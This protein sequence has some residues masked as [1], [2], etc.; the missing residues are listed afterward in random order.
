MSAS[1]TDKTYD[2]NRSVAGGAE[3]LSYAWHARNQPFWED[4]D[5]TFCERPPLPS[6][7]H[8]VGGSLFSRDEREMRQIALDTGKVTRFAPHTHVVP[9]S[10]T[11]WY[12]TKK[13]EGGVSL[14]LM[15]KEKNP[16]STQMIR[17]GLKGQ[18]SW[19]SQLVTVNASTTLATA[20]I[21]IAGVA[22]PD[23]NDVLVDALES[24]DMEGLFSNVTYA[25][26]GARLPTRHDAHPDVT[27]IDDTL[28]GVERGV[29]VTSDAPMV[30]AVG[31]RVV[32]SCFPDE[33]YVRHISA[34]KKTVVVQPRYGFIVPCSNAVMQSVRTDLVTFRRFH[35]LSSKH[36]VFAGR[37]R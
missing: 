7:Q 2:G 24:A 3:H 23:T 10:T 6:E 19:T 37:R 28:E 31:Q 26:A 17:V 36:L 33:T 8:F 34:D 4:G 5:E 35:G 1:L 14:E 21:G 12:E 22:V 29:R 27:S 32:A 9:G 30:L 25:L 11:R 16:S 13:D 18:Y 15:V 20:N